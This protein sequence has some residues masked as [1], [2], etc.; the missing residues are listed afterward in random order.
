MRPD[1]VITTQRYGGEPYWVIKDPVSLK[2][3]HL[4]EGEYAILE[5]LDG[6]TTT[7][8]E[9]KQSFNQR[10]APRQL[11]SD[12]LH[13]FL[14]QM[15]QAGLLLSEAVGQGASMLERRERRRRRELLQRM[16]NVLAI[17]FRGLNPDPFLDRLYL[18]V[19]PLFSRFF[20]TIVGLL[21]GAAALLILLRI[22]SLLARM[23]RLDTLFTVQNIAALAVALASVKILHELAHA[24][25]CKHF[26][27][28]CHE[29]GLMLLV[30]T[31]C[32]Y[33][34]V[35]DSWMFS[36]RWQRI[37][38]SAAGMIVEIA[39]ASVCTF[40]WWLSEPGLL[41]TLC[42]NVMLISSV[43]TLLLN[44]NPLLRY[45]GYYILSDV[46]EIPNLAQQS[47]AAL[48]HL[49]ARL[50]L[51]TGA[52]ASESPDLPQRRRGLLALYAAASIAYRL[53]LV[54]AILW[55]LHRALTAAHLEA[56]VPALAA[57]IL[58]GM[59]APA[60]HRAALYLRQPLSRPPLN[61]AR[62]VMSALVLAALVTAILTIPVPTHVAAPALLEYHNAQ[63]VYIPVAGTLCDAVAPGTVVRAGE[64]LARIENLDVALQ[65]ARLRAD[66]D[67]QS[68]RL[69]NLE[70][71]RGDDPAAAQQIPS[72]RQALAGL[73]RRLRQL[74]RD[75][76]RLALTAPVSGTVLPP[77]HRSKEPLGEGQLAGW[78]GQPL[79][80]T[81]RGSYLETGT[82]LCLI[83]DRQQFHATVV[84]DQSDIERVQVGQSVRVR[85]DQLPGQVLCGTIDEIAKIDLQ[86]AP[87]ERTATDQLLTR[88]R[89]PRNSRQR[90]SYEARLRL[91]NPP[92]FLK[93]GAAGAAKIVTARESLGRQLARY[94][95]RTFRVEL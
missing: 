17:R 28:R 53:V 94:L 32:L 90:T 25:V 10:F 39:L 1:L 13:R 14:A 35:S 44:G 73:E 57:M 56:I 69:Q 92:T 30:F 47:R 89:W 45:D 88:N 84:I 59:A 66:R 85:L 78:Y 36:N 64:R 15:H 74:L 9:I 65:V 41:N 62:V 72:A 93:G 68:L 71:R 52:G 16:S 81:N 19:R 27:G 18:W 86:V 46:V 22:D 43:G 20:L 87:R 21:C 75:Q 50:C 29:L 38:V 83:G 3:F 79:S 2:Y 54:V 42:F 33:C 95:A 91:E 12:H 67:A 48:R 4:R 23:P 51:G 24:L 8:A 34:N 80:R 5:L 61:R 58:L 76:S 49:L 31:P 37:A 70:A 6:R 60:L 7:V 63:R 40:L 55:M 77:P 11:S 82:L 26:G